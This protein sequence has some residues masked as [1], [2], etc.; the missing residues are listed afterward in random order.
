MI[1][2]LSSVAHSSSVTQSNVHKLMLAVCRMVPSKLIDI[3]QRCRSL[4]HLWR[5]LRS[6][7][8]WLEE[9]GSLMEVQ[10][11]VPRVRWHLG[12]APCDYFDSMRD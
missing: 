4:R 6:N 7:G 11:A 12:P 2:A 1:S 5:E 8:S 9:A 10:R 3:L